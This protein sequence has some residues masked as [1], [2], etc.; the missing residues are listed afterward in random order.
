M[1]QSAD[2]PSVMITGANGFIGSR[3]VMHFLVQ[4]FHVVAGVRKTSDLG[5]L[6]NLDIEYRYGDVTQ[7]DTLPE[8]V[9]EI[10]RASCRERV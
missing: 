10:G 5:F 3:M 9:R 4:G 8:M 7:P 6:E 1:N 2:K